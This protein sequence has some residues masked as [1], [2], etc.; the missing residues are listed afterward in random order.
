M[1]ELVHIC[2]FS[3]KLWV[4]RPSAYVLCDRP[5]VRI[6]QHF[7]VK[8]PTKVYVYI[9]NRVCLGYSSQRRRSKYT[10]ARDMHRLWG[11][12]CRMVAFVVIILNLPNWKLDHQILL[13]WRT[14]MLILAFYAF[15]DLSFQACKWQ[16]DRQTDKQTDNRR[17]RKKHSAKEGLR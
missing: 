13:S 10:L 5:A 2:L 16:T 1:L 7:V 12:F 8:F 11:V 4:C 17:T 9:A 14:L 3:I 15:W 6:I